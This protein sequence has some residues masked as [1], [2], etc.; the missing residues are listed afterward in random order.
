MNHTIASSTET[1]TLGI[2]HLKRYWSAAMAQRQ[3]GQLERKGEADLDKQMLNALGLGL[4]QTLS[5]L[6]SRA[7]SFDEFEAWAVAT[8]GQPDPLQVARLNADIEGQPQPAEIEQWVA[9]IEASEPVLSDDDLA[10]WQEHGYVVLKNAVPEETRAAAERQIW[11]HVG[12]DP[13]VPDSWYGRSRED[14]HGIMVELIQHPAFEANRRSARIH[15]AFAQL[16]GTA[17]LWVSADRCGFHPPQRPD[18]PF[19][20]PDLHWDIDFDRPLDFGTQGILYLTDT[21]PE[22]GALTV[23]PGFQHRLADWLAT[24]PAGADPQKQDLH[25]LGSRPIGAGAGDMVIWHHHLPHGP[26]PNLGTRP[27]MVQY[28]NLLPGCV[29]RRAPLR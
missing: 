28:I 16:W 25:A 10:F 13:D 11:Q 4:H 27:R 1:G 22:Q 8:G 5:Y 3:G 21:P 9:A 19:P 6:F 20:G 17:N 26:R 29:Y 23:V 24:L 2:Y 15:K 14:I 7:P 12:A 18:H